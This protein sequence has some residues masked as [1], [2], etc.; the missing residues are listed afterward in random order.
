MLFNIGPSL[1]I[2]FINKKSSSDVM[3]GSYFH[4]EP[5]GHVIY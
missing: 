1:F 3:S 4:E 5:N 2:K